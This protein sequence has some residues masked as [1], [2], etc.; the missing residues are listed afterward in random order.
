MLQHNKCC[1]LLK[2]LQQLHAGIMLPAVGMRPGGDRWLLLQ[3]VRIE[4]A[5]LDKAIRGVLERQLD[6]SLDQGVLHDEHARLAR[7][8]EMKETQQQML[9]SSLI[10]TAHE[11]AS[12]SSALRQS[13][14]FQHARS[15][16]QCSELALQ[17]CL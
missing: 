16:V 10:D 14:A 1:S 6:S 11:Q 12:P 17:S 7:L 8:R 9:I 13:L 5:E 4:A 15:A 2:S 3:S